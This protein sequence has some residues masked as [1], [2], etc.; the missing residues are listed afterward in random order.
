LASIPAAELAHEI[1]DACLREG[2]WP[3]RALDDLI[4]RALDE[5]DRFLAMAATRAL[6]GIVIEQLGDLFEPHLC[7]VYARL[8]SHVIS[9][10][11]PEHD[12]GDLLVRYRRVRQVRRFP[13]GE[14]KRVF[15]LS[16]VTLGADI[17]VTS[18]A[19]AAAK[20]R[21]PDAEI[22]MVAPAKNAELFAADPRIVPIA[23]M[24][25]RS[26]LL[27]DRLLA[28]AELQ[29]AVD[30]LGSIVI[31]P[32]SR[33]TQLGLI[34]ICDD[35]RYFF[36]E[37]RA[38]GGELQASLPQ[39]T[40]E[41]LT[42]VFDVEHLSTYA[43]PLKQQ[44]IAEIT[45]S[46]GVGEN[47]NKRIDDEFEY[48]VLSALLDRGQPVLLDRGAG[49]EEAK[50]V[51]A[52]V[53]RLGS[54]PNLHVHDGS[55]ASFASHILQ[56]R[57]YVGYD[58]AGQHVAAAGQVPL[59]SVFNGYACD[60][61]LSRWRPDG[62]SAHVVAVTPGDPPAALAQTLQAIAAAGEEEASAASM[63]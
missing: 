31:D 32:D 61:M 6:F 9:R 53:N 58:S 28:A 23:I 36:F 17:A 57:L 8:F 45:V 56:S 40:S 29:V 14:V 42:E 51:S 24:Y 35:S 62:H 55:Y 11:L 54:P 10:A 26:S 34:P 7:D 1:L 15:V 37:S 22:C 19:L 25:G 50:R 12:A 27:R 43:A 39:L 46:W 60:R 2:T 30:E 3:A 49:G 47:G 21:F 38:Y 63:D 13:G 59:V 44:K 20:L 4:E 48:Q 33:L 5:D 52:L 18:L 41:W 16:R